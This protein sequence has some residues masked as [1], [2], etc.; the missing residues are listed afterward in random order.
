[1]TLIA[2]LVILGGVVFD[3]V[4]RTKSTAVAIAGDRIVRVGSDKSVRELIG[5]DTRVVEAAGGLI[6]PGFVDAHVHAAFA[7]VERLSLDLTPATTVEETLEDSSAMRPGAA[8]RS[9][10][11]E[12]AG[13]TSCSRCRRVISSTRSCPTGRWR[14]ATPA[15]H[16]TLW[17]NSRALELAGVDRDTPQPHNGVIYKDDAGEPIGYLNESAA[18]LVG[19]II[20][21]VT[22]DEIFA[23]L[24]NAQ[25]H[26]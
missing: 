4:V 12:A 20:P 22:D 1:M 9:G 19:R 14:S 24:L 2:D 21:P 10:S 5:P 25:S 8:T 15:R 13:T 6:H 3:G 7:G 18:E 23:G 17:V 11:P 26:L 16:H